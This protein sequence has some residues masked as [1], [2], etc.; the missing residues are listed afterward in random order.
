MDSE[1]ASAPPL[2][3]HHPPGGVVDVEDGPVRP[4]HPH[5]VVAVLHQ[6]H[7]TVALLLAGA[8]VA[9]IA[10]DGQDACGPTVRAGDRADRD[11][12][13]FDRAPHGRGLTDEAA[14]LPGLGGGNGRSRFVIA[15]VPPEVGPGAPGDG[16]EVAHLHHLLPA[17][18]HEG[19]TGIEI[20]NLDA[21][22]GAG[23]HAREEGFAFGEPSQ[24][25][26]LLHGEPAR[27]RERGAQFGCEDGDPGRYQHEQDAADPLGVRQPQGLARVP[28]R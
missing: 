18:R 16:V 12:P 2:Q 6:A 25:I 27:A 7:E 9:D 28:D 11:M 8:K 23:K 4:H 24:R 1:P 10:R 15:L 21:V 17:F 20:E 3:A 19:E 22:G 26:I 5:E 13:P 14:A